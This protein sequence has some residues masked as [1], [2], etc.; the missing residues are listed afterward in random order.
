MTAEN[1]NEFVMVR[2]VCQTC[3]YTYAQA[4]DVPYAHVKALGAKLDTA[5]KVRI[6][7]YTTLLDTLLWSVMNMCFA[8][9]FVYIQGLRRPAMQGS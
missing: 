3:I 5:A 6:A 8:C 1:A 7:K 2:A 4:H 9:L